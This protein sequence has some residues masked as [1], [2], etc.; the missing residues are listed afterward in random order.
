[1]LF[2]GQGSQR[3]GMGRELY[4]AFPVFAAAWDEVC[5]RFDR[6]PVDDE[7][8]LNRTDGAQAA[9][10]ALEVALFRLLE[11]WGVRPEFLLGHSIGEIS[12]AH[13]AGVLSLDD[14]CALVAARGRLMAALPAGGA[15]LA[16]EVSEEDVP[17]GM[18]I[19]A[20][21]SATSL[22]VSGTGEEISALEERWR[23]EGRRVK[24]L[25]VSHAFHS[26][27]MEPMLADFAVV[28]ESLTYH[29]PRI[30]LPGAVTDPA[31]W[32]RQVR[33][34]VRFADGVAWLRE[35][36]VTSFLE[37]GPDPV[38]SSHVEDAAAVLRDGRGEAA[39]LLTAVGRVWVRGATVDWPLVVPVGRRVDLPT[40]PFARQ[41]FWPAPAVRRGDVADAGLGVTDLYHVE[42]RE[43]AVEPEPARAGERGYRALFDETMLHRVQVGDRGVA[44]VEP[45]SADLHR[46]VQSVLSV[47]QDWL[48]ST[49]A[50]DLVIVT[51]GAVAVRPDDPAPDPV[52]AACWGLVR[53]AQA[54]HPGRVVLVDTDGDVDAAVRLAVA[55]GEPAVALRGNSL[56]TPRLTRV[57]TQDTTAVVIDPGRAV[58]ITGGT[59]MLGGLLAR[60]LVTAYGVRELVLTSRRGQDADGAAELTAELT[61]LGAEVVIA[62]CD[63]ADPVAVAALLADHPVGA[64]F[65]TAG[66]VDDGLVAT[67]TPDALDRVFS[68]K[69]DAARILHELTAD[70]DLTAFVL[71]SSISGTVGSPGQGNYAA[72]NAVLDALAAHRRQAGL[73]ALSL[74]WGPWDTE[75][76]MVGALADADR[77]RIARSGFPPLDPAHALALLDKALRLGHP[78][79]VPVRLDPAAFGG[80][81]PHLLRELIRPVRR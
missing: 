64:V 2:T 37:L 24:R 68:P 51:S 38:L 40:Y 46:G 5:S 10:F 80:T 44:V 79:V 49:G 63:V 67:L 20:V 14:A 31:Y 81:P 54:E 72:A 58:L 25:V 53:S 56:F 29:E 78:A 30:P 43:R 15:M 71:F 7:V 28:A 69:A 3:V 9:I 27:L 65:H 45:Y 8:L 66:V 26:T 32:V 73:P 16:A 62:A 76:G 11:S 59:G 52:G 35:R 42:W 18:D 50:D 61:A 36:G 48:A 57:S 21:N 39:T 34:T 41:R 75:R 4:A 19:A 70:A 13:V 22:V 17:V 23:S 55:G 47:V 77:A 6:V 74:A 1:F 60:H 33:D 12:A